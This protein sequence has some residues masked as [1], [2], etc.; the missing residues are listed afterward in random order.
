[1]QSSEINKLFDLLDEWRL[2][3]AYQLERRADIFFA[4][5]LS[6]V[7]EQSFPDSKVIEII[8][9]FPVRIGSINPTQ[10]KNNQ[11]FKVDYLVICDNQV[12]L[13]ELK[14]DLNSRRTQQDQ[15]LE[16]AKDA[17]IEKLIDGVLRI[18]TAT[19]SK[20]KYKRLLQKLESISWLKQVDGNW[21]NTSQD[22][23]MQ[24]V[25]IQPLASDETVHPVI[26]FEQFAKVVR[27]EGTELAARFADSLEEWKKNPEQINPS[28]L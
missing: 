1:M 4:L 5:Y 2:L 18:Y 16:Q 20:T 12:L 8:P 11:S 7:I 19:R 14:T 25:Y 10:T 13:V 15:Y 27:R 26:N 22:Q 23:E 3:P 24:I 9:E 21:V 17:N 6:Q 28:P